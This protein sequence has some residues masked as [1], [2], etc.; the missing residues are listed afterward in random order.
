MTDIT[1]VTLGQNTTDIRKVTQKRLISKVTWKR[2]HLERE[3]EMA[4][5]T[6]V[7]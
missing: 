7:T 6:K 2:S 1:K 3:G 4:D 5:V